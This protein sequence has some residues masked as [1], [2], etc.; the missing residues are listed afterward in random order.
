MGLGGAVLLDGVKVNTEVP[1]TIN[2]STTK[3]W[4]W[5]GTSVLGKSGGERIWEKSFH[6]LLLII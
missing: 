6:K 5:Y 1:F 2:L 4:G 3:E